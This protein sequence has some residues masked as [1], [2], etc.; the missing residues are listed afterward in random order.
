MPD[1]APCPT[2]LPPLCL[3]NPTLDDFT[4][5]AELG[6]RSSRR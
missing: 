5:K 2:L 1:R 4:R 6:C 3:Q